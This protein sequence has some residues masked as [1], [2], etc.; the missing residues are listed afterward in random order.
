MPGTFNRGFG[1][2]GR[3]GGRRNRFLQFGGRGGWFNRGAGWG[4]PGMGYAPDYVQEDQ[5]ETLQAQATHLEKALEGI[6]RRIRE[7]E[8]GQKEP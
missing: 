6:K 3:G 8:T 7:L 4:A 5:V 2:G 1:F